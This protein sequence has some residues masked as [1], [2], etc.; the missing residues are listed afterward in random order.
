MKIE[1]DEQPVRLRNYLKK[2]IYPTN[3]YFP[4]SDLSTSESCREDKRINVGENGDD[5]D[6]YDG[7]VTNSHRFGTV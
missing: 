6:E 1:R 4:S 5:V 2:N 7:G 3:I